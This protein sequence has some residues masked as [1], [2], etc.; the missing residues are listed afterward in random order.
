MNIGAK[1]AYLINRMSDQLSSW[2]SI[3]QREI[4]ERRTLA[5]KT[6]TDHVFRTKNIVKK[7]VERR[8]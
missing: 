4:I 7:M 6:P 5:A 3:K 2:T 8:N 1:L